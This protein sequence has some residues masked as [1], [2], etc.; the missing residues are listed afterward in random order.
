MVKMKPGESLKKP[1]QL[2]PEPNGASVQLQW[3]C[4]HCNIY[5]RVASHP[6][7]LQAF[8]EEWCHQDK[9]HPCPSI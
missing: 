2:L 1:R 7:I 3:R 8:G 4:Y 5:Q 6:L 9:G